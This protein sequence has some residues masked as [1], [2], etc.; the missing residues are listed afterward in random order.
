MAFNTNY[1]SL[2]R[3]SIISTAT[4]RIKYYPEALTVLKM[5]LKELRELSSATTLELVIDNKN[6]YVNITDGGSGFNPNELK[7]EELKEILMTFC[8]LHEG[9]RL[10]IVLD[11]FLDWTDSD[12]FRRLNGAE[13]DFYKNYKPRNGQ[14]LDKRE[15]LYIR[16][17]NSELYKCVS[18]LINV[19]GSGKFSLNWAPL[20]QLKALGLPATLIEEIKKTRR[21]NEKKWDILL[22][23]VPPN[24]KKW[25]SLEPSGIYKVNV[26]LKNSKVSYSFLW[27]EGRRKILAINF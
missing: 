21:N 2:W 11:S 25:I 7:E 6:W 22:S 10:S 20:R 14:I 1:S 23:Q 18:P 26:Q 13:E 19:Y 27:D 5:S 3:Y 8:N 4:E 24:I 15:L 9:T 12:S 16:G 17:F